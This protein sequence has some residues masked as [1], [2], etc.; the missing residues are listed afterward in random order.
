MT[1]GEIVK[2]EVD[3]DLFDLNLK[4]LEGIY[5]SDLSNGKSLVYFEQNGEWAELKSEDFTRKNPNHVS[6]KN[7]DFISKIKKLEYTFQ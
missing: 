3:Y 7:R 1:K 4:D 6:K 2:V 5:V